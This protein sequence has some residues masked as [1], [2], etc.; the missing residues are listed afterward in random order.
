M[1]KMAFLTGTI[2]SGG[3]VMSAQGIWKVNQKR[4]EEGQRTIRSKR[5][6]K[7]KFI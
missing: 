3:T 1:S 5:L 2:E 4:R 6:A 7:V